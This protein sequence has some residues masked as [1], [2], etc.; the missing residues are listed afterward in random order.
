[1]LIPFINRF[2]H[3]A[4]VGLVS[5]ILVLMIMSKGV[6][7]EMVGVAMAALSVSV[8]LLELPSGVLSDTIGRRR[9][10]LVSIGLAVAAYALMIA[11]GSLAGVTVALSLYGVSRAFSSGSIE[12]LYVDDY[13]AERGKDSLHSL[14]AAMSAGEILG[15]AAGAL[16]GGFIPSLWRRLAPLSSPYNGNVAA[17]IALLCVLFAMTVATSRDG[18]AF[19]AGKAAGA[20]DP[21]RVPERGASSGSRLKGIIRESIGAIRGNRI[22]AGMLAGAV[23]WGFSFSAIEVYWQPRLREVLAGTDADWLFGVVNSAYFAAALAGNAI[24][25]LVARKFRL[26]SSLAI[27]GAL[28]IATGC[29]IVA[30]AF[31]GA[32]PGFSAL[33]L[34]VMC[35]NGMMSIPESAAFNAA[36]PGSARASLLSL[37]SLS[38]QVGGIASSLAFSAVLRFAPVSAAWIIAGGLL[39]GSSLIY[40][41]VGGRAS[42]VKSRALRAS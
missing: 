8:V 25:G 35:C 7:V 14:V 1:M 28:R 29:A 11:A 38:V 10:Y 23:F 27:I 5:P 37:A 30:L 22:I 33:F 20:G 3:W 13:I 31:Q 34:T 9:V 19:R 32:V 4:V 12:A 18:A 36:I 6:G 21:G 39:L 26:D 17:Q 40:F 42:G 2:L 15:L 41:G 24:I 16:A